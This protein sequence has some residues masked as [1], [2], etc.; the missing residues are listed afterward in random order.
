LCRAVDTLE[1]EDRLEPTGRNALFDPFDLLL[2]GDR[3]APDAFED[4]QACVGGDGPDGTLCRGAALCRSSRARSLARRDAIC[5][6][7]QQMSAGMRATCARA[8]AAG[9]ALRLDDL[10]DLEPYCY[11]VARTVGNLLTALFEHTVPASARPCGS[12]CASAP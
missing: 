3:A 8:H 7:V 5:P 12:R 2:A 10:A 6:H 1:D 9:G 11:F 4:A